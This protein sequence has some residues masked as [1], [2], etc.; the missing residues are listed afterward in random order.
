MKG[1]G[2]LFILIGLGLGYNFTVH[3]LDYFEMKSKSVVV[4]GRVTEVSDN[5]SEVK[6]WKAYEVQMDIEFNRSGVLNVTTVCCW[7]HSKYEREETSCAQIGDTK[8]VR[9]VPTALQG[10]VSK[11]HLLQVTD[12]GDYYDFSFSF[13]LFFIPFVFLLLGLAFVWIGSM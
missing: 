12:T 2:I 13:F 9:Y 7:C 11:P 3:M 10:E 4:E 5:R 1:F 8:M 6:A